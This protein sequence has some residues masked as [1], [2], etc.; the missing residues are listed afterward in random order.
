MRPFRRWSCQ[1]VQILAGL[2]EALS[3]RRIIIGGRVGL[4][5]WILFGILSDQYRGIVL[6]CRIEFNI[7]D[8]AVLDCQANIFFQPAALNS[9]M[10][11]S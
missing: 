5:L 1:I 8:L 9:G 11:A 4:P 6:L 7:C 3:D 2:G 10:T